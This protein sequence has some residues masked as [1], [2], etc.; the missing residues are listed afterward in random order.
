VA[1]D[2]TPRG[3]REA[4]PQ[5]RYI[6]EI[7]M[8]MT[9]KTF[10]SALVPAPVRV[11]KQTSIKS[12]DPTLPYFGIYVEALHKWFVETTL[13]DAVAMFCAERDCG[14]GGE[15]CVGYGASEIGCEFPL[16]L[17]AT[18][19]KNKRRVGSVFYNGNVKLTEV[20]S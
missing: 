18:G 5:E 13:E 7:K 11:P 3:V 8:K 17:M 14:T 2:E 12:H 4:R 9:K 19:T 20:L 6:K 10:E 15:C 16:Y 1:G